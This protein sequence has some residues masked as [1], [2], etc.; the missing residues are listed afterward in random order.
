MRIYY[1]QINY[2]QNNQHKYKNVVSYIKKII[3]RLQKINNKIELDLLDF[4]KYKSI[5]YLDKLC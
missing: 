3:G 2:M 1:S 5:S 4:L